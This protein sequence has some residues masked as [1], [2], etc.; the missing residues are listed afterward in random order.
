MK[1]PEQA[2]TSKNYLNAGSSLI[3]FLIFA[4]T[5]SQA[6]SQDP[7]DIIKGKWL[8]HTDAQNSLYNHLTE[9]AYNLLE[10]RSEVLS[11]ITTAGEWTERQKFIKNTLN[12]IAGPFPDRT[13]L[14]A[15]VVRTI[16]KAQPF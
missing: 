14:N 15:N 10:Q 2:G 13:P 7:T 3:L 12:E 6:W 4:F 16:D 1:Q 11:A 5:G 8:I 9:K